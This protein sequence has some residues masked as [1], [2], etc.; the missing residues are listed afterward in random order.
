MYN[1]MERQID[2]NKKEK[3]TYAGHD[4]YNVLESRSLDKV[5]VRMIVHLLVLI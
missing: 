2:D 3:V 4:D 1:N 5:M